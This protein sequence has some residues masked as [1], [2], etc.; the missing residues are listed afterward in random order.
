MSPS[1]RCFA[2]LAVALIAASAANAQPVYARGYDPRAYGGYLY[3]EP[4]LAPAVVVPA[5]SSA[6][7]YTLTTYP[8]YYQDPY[9][10]TIQGLASLTSATGQY[11]KDVQTARIYREQSRQASLET[12]RQ[13]LQLQME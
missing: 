12:A 3:T 5:F 10:A 2:A 7:P 1:L 6:G 13:R 8:L 9:S 11:Y 4:A